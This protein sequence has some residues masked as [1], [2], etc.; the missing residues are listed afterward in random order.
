M[1][2]YIKEIRNLV[3]HRPIILVACGGALLNEH[4]Q[5]LL[6]ERADTGNWSIPGGFM[7]YGES[8]KQTCAREFAE[9]SGIKVEVGRH[10]G[11]FDQDFSTY[12][13]GDVTQVIGHL[14]EVHQI[15]GQPLDHVTDETL[16][17]QWFDLDS[18]PTI[19]FSQN[20][21]MLNLIKQIYLPNKTN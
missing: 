13:N 19:Q 16:S 5:I 8:L 7:E 20:E 2:N 6:Q 14:F 4:K 10:L 9:D 18:L 21:K 17:T 11:Y 15:G 12:P 1:A 3:G